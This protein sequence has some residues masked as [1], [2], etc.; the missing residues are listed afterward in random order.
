MN[1]EFGSQQGDSRQTPP[2]Y[3][4]PQY[5][6]GQPQYGQPQYGYSQAQSQTTYAPPPPTGGYAPP[7][8]R[9]TGGK[10][11][12]WIGFLRVFLWIWF[13]VICLFG[14]VVFSFAAVQG[15]TAAAWGLLTLVVSV[16]IGFLS[17]AAGMVAL[18]ACANL[19][20]CAT[21]SARILDLLQEQKKN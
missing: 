18:D 2:S 13:A 10:G 14:L 17:I 9:S 19:S 4:Q 3:G 6:G 5:G 15:G 8:V 1:D 7:P 20:R 12:G 11:G 21:N 16:L